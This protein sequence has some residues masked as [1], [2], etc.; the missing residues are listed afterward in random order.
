MRMLE[1]KKLTSGTG[2]AIGLA[3]FIFGLPGHIEDAF[4]WRTWIVSL[5]IS[6]VIGLIGVLSSILYAASDWWR[7]RLFKQDESEEYNSRRSEE[8]SIPHAAG[9]TTSEDIRPDAADLAHTAEYTIKDRIYTRVNPEQMTDAFKDLTDVHARN[10]VRPYIG[11]WLFLDEK[12]NN[13][14][15][16]ERI[17]SVTVFTKKHDISIFLGFK[18]EWRTS[19]ITLQKETRIV[20]A[21]RITDIDHWHIRL[22]D[23]ELYH[24]E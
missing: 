5:N 7:P 13:V 3:L 11:R 8:V 17:N 2:A 22:E 19:V 24:Y 10:L 20:A 15:A 18:E 21:G 16:N 4:T 6:Q 23:C 9:E 1:R 14:W 12:I